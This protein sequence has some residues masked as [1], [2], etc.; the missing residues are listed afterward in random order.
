[1]AIDSNVIGTDGCQR[2][3]A[4]E[5]VGIG[6]SWGGP[7]P[8]E[9]RNNL[10]CG[11]EI[12]VKLC[13]GTLNGNRFSGNTVNL[14]VQFPCYP[15]EDIIAESNWWG[16]TNPDEIETSIVDCED[17]PVLESCVDYVPWCLDEDCT[18]SAAFPVSWG[19]VKALYR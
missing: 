8:V 1:V 3:G 18:Q 10:I 9:V 5:S 19:S 13:R 12:G 14:Q 6:I 11:K 7:G 15:W 4:R 2:K 16:T 17:D